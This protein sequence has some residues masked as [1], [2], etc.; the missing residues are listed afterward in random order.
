M[1]SWDKQPRTIFSNEK[2]NRDPM[3]LQA[4]DMT[5]EKKVYFVENF[6]VV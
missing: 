5:S 6:A 2:I 4:I 3:D 1:P